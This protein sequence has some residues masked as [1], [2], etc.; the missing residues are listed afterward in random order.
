MSGLSEAE[1]AAIEKE[2]GVE[3]SDEIKLA[4]AASNGL[5]GPTNIWLLFPSSNDINEDIVHMNTLRD[6]DW[7]PRS[8]TNYAI[9]GTD[10]G[11]GLICVSRHGNA[12]IWH[13]VE[14]E[15]FAE[16]RETVGEIWDLIRQ[17]YS[18]AG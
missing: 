10:G 11:S 5:R 14:G 1:V 16:Q 8:L 3:L 17:L 4:Y 7:F 18:E 12:V 15:H 6:E 2:I 13:P 9:V